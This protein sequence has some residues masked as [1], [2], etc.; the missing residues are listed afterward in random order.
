MSGG[1]FA[2]GFASPRPSRD[3]LLRRS[4]SLTIAD[5][6]PAAAGHGSWP[7]LVG[8][9]IACIGGCA[10]ARSGLTVQA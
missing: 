4:D 5:V 10:P 1:V 7:R 6:T 2:F 8:A 3:A 9:R